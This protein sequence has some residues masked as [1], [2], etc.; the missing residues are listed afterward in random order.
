MNIKEV[1]DRIREAL[2]N[3][4]FQGNI[5]ALTRALATKGY[6]YDR[7]A[8]SR[9]ISGDRD[10]KISEID[11]L[12]D[13]LGVSTHFLQYGAS[14]NASNI[15]E[16]RRLTVDEEHQEDEAYLNQR[17][18]GFSS[19]TGY[20]PSIEGGIPEID[21]LAGAGN[22]AIGEVVSLKV[23]DG[24]VSAHHVIDEWKIPEEYLG[25]VLNVSA[26]RSL[27]LPVIGD[28][29]IPSYHPGDR[30]LVDLRQT[31]MTIDAVYVISDGESPPQIK[32]LQRV[33]FSHP[34]TVDVISDNPSHK[35]QR[36]EIAQLTIIGRVAGKVSKQ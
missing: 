9:M 17:Q 12:A 25:Q 11:A 13:A 22:G 21:V 28:S 4:I 36:V 6:T 33:L 23:G 7:S 27:I 5:S 18:L 19:A 15:V 3:S 1:R 32:R 14:E 31:E 34:A 26:G 35:P 8:V 16:L 10:I 24:S 29:M 30:I 2:E 20:E